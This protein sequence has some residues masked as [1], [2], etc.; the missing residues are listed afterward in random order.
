MSASTETSTPVRDR[1]R[2]KVCCI[3]SVAEAVAKVRPWGVDVCSGLRSAGRLDE[4]KLRR[5][6]DA[7]GGR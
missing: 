2:L 7:L 6:A 5:F 3:R 1:V 4:D